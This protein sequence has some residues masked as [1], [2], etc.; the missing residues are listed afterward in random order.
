MRVSGKTGQV[1]EAFTMVSPKKRAA[2]ARTRAPVLCPLNLVKALPIDSCLFMWLFV[3]P[4]WPF[5]LLRRIFFDVLQRSLDVLLEE[6]H[7]VTRKVLAV[8]HR[9]SCFLSDARL[10]RALPKDRFHQLFECS[11]LIRDP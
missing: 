8:R 7:F 9:Q 3:N 10:S 6:F 4:K 5:V 11:P 1:P 2:Q